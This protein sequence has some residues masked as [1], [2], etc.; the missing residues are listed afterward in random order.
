MVTTAFINIW[1]KRVGAVAWNPDTELASF[2]YD[3]KFPLEK[4]SLAPLK[5]PDISRIYN[6]PQLRDNE[7]FKGLPG[8]LADALPDRYG[9]EMINAWLARQGR[10][11]NSLN[12]VE[13]L[14]FIGKRGMGALEFEPVISKESGS[15]DV[16]ISDLI[17]VTKALLEKKE[18]IQLIMQ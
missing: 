15:Y 4:W 18:N 8:L 1:G 3:P 14:C 6:F 11:D 12:P 13:L 10:P 17:E 7:T 2:E 16:E 5:M 9:K